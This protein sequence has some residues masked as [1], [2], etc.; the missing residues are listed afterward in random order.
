VSVTLRQPWP[1][2][3]GRVLP[4][5]TGKLTWAVSR[6]LRVAKRLPKALRESALRKID[7]LAKRAQVKI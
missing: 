6:S 5:I 1:N 2:E 7:E 4:V 3:T